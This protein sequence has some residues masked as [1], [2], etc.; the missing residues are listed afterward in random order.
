MYCESSGGAL[1]PVKTNQALEALDIAN[2]LFVA[3][4]YRLIGK[5]SIW[6]NLF[7]K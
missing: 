6:R 2:I 5:C 7:E 4:F 3:T 1:E